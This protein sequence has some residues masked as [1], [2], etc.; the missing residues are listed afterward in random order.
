MTTHYECYSHINKKKEEKF[1]FATKGG[2]RS[3]QIKS[4]DIETL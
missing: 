3:F 2:A 4:G 1:E